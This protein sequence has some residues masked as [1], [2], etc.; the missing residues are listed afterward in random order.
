MIRAMQKIIVIV[1]PTASGKSSLA[2]KMARKLKGEVISA[3]SRQVYKGLDIGTG[4]ITKKEMQGVPHHL[5]DVASPKKVFTANDFLIQGRAAIEDI[6]ARGNTPIICGGTGF[7]VDALLGR[8]SLPDVAANPKLRNQL[9]KKS[10]AQLFAIL[11]KLD[12]RRAKDI[13]AQNPV[14]LVRA[15]EIAKALGKVPEKKPR[16]LPY[17]IEWIG[18]KPEEKKLRANIKK[19]LLARMKQGMLREA[20][21][22]HEGGLSYKRMH[23][24]GLEYRYLA[25]HLQGKLSKKEMLEKLENE[26]WQYAK[27]Q[28]AYFKRNTDIVWR[29][30]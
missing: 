10:A 12:P 25:L 14:R 20:K 27:R 4:K 8:I 17:T 28:I 18:L 29:S 11:K 23:Q 22:L 30:K 3:D 7:Y 9:S 1:G 24:L 5:L 2:V 13:D 26:I 6:L 15:I 16:P 19:R 21:K